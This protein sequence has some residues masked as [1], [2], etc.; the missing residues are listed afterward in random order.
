M[1]RPARP[2]LLLVA[3]REWRWLMRDRLAPLLIFGVP[4]LAFAILIA[5]FT[6]PVI[7]GLRT[8]VID[9][10]R[11]QSSRGLIEVLAA[12][13]NLRIAERA[14][15]LSSATRALRSGNAIAA[16]HIPANFE[17]DLKAQ[18]RPQVVAF[19]NQEQLTAAGLAAQG[20]RDALLAAAQRAAPAHGSAPAAPRIGTLAVQ[21]IVLVNPERNYAQFLLRSLLPM[22]L[23]VVIA[24]TAGYAVGTEFRRRSMRTWLACAGG[25]PIVAI[26]GKLLPLFLVFTVMMSVVALIIEGLFGIAFRG[27]AAM[28]V[29]AAALFIVAYLSLGAVLQLLTRNLPT[30]LSATAIVVSPAFGFAGVGFPILGM[31]T[32]SQIYGALL[33]LRWYESILLDQAAR[34]I[35]VAASAIAFTALGGLA[36]LYFLLALYRL[37]AIRSGLNRAQPDVAIPA[38]G[39]TSRGIAAEVTAEWRRVLINRGAFGLLV[40]APVFYGVFYPQPYRTEILRDVP[41]AVVDNDLNGFSRDIVDALDASGSVKVALRTDTLNEAKRALERGKVF[42]IVGIPPDT[43]RDVLKGNAVPL[44]VYV[45]ATYLFLYKAAA[46]G[47]SDAIGSVVSNLAAGGARIDGSLARAALASTSPADILLQPIFNPVGGYAS[48]VV[49]AAFILIIQQTLL[50]GSAMLTGP[51][52]TRSRGRLVTTVLGRALAHWMLAIPALLLYLIVLPRMY[53]LPALGRPGELLVLATPFVLATSLLGQA[54]GARFKNAETP[55][56]LFLALSI[57]AFFLVGF[58]WPREAIPESVLAAGS[59]FPSEFAIDGL[60][61]LNQTGAGLHELHRDWLG[62]WCLAGLYFVLAVLSAWFKRRS[63]HG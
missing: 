37:N 3:A 19:Y 20:L 60:V 53:G 11:S 8:V 4:L 1:K 22:V 46:A 40:L 33:P 30:G 47:I 32:F 31:N 12:S 50:M 7:R 23:H 52:L 59:I 9:D 38:V 26:V 25:N 39:P 21:N 43:Q 48:Y 36:V 10:D 49:P 55:V 15:D 61:H 27:D 34:G 24:V 44:P 63:E 35:P 13:P 28:M 58:A 42:A 51:A 5:V 41:I 6:H 16:V 57:P 29:A 56:L 45:D 14:E 62:L 18:R 2:G 17:R 54:A